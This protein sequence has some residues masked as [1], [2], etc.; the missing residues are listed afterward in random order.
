MLVKINADF[1]KR[2][3]IDV[4][5]LSGG[6]SQIHE[7]GLARETRHELGHH[8]SFEFIVRAG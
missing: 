6:V 8:V 1:R 5:R 2:D 4:C 3:V 7:L